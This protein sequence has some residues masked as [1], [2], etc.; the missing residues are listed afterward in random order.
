M[1]HQLPLYECDKF[2]TLTDIQKLKRQEDLM[3]RNRSES[4]KKPE[5]D[6]Q[7]ETKKRKCLMCAQ[8]FSSAWPGERICP[9]C[10]QTQA[11]S[12]GHGMAA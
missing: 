9:S 11:W 8:S 3:A 5:S 4:V 12:D 1:T 10:K 6:R 2:V 7:H